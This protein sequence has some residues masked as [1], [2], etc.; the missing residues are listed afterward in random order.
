MKFDFPLLWACIW[1]TWKYH[2]SMCM[3]IFLAYLWNE[4]IPS[5][6]HYSLWYTYGPVSLIIP[7]IVVVP[8]ILIVR[9]SYKHYK[10]IQKYYPN[11]YR[12]R[13]KQ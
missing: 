10:E 3:F 5:E 6:D 9:D 11:G 12:N 2:L 8:M 7:L 1:K 13:N 4:L